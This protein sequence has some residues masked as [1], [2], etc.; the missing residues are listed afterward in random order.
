MFEE[1]AYHVFVS[2]IDEPG[3]RRDDHGAAAAGEHQRR[4]AGGPAEPD[5]TLR[6]LNTSYQAIARLDNPNGHAAER[7]IGRARIETPTA[8]AARGD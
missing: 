3:R 4:A 8:D 7:L 1:S 5:G 2:T 6:P